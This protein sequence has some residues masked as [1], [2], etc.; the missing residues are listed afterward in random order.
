MN[1]N[2]RK[3]K[4]KIG[5]HQ[6][7]KKKNLEVKGKLRIFASSNM[8][9][10]YPGRIPRGVRLYRYCPIYREPSFCD[11]SLFL[12]VLHH[13]VPDIGLTKCILTFNGDCA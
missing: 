9:F 7:K 8:S 12:F 11:C 10:D 3:I 5:N 13:K 6:R 4:K 2:E 1:N